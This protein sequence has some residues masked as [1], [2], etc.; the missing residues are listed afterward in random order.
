MLTAAAYSYLANFSISSSSFL[1]CVWDS[2]LRQLQAVFN[3]THQRIHPTSFSFLSLRVPETLFFF[4][5]SYFF[6]F[7][8][9]RCKGQQN[10]LSDFVILL[11]LNWWSPGVLPNE[12]WQNQVLLMPEC[13]LR[14]ITGF[15]SMNT[16][17]WWCLQ[18]GATITTAK[19]SNLLGDFIKQWRHFCF[20]FFS[21]DHLHS[22]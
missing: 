14:T 21:H 22:P 12:R 5:V 8:F 20:N 4:I 7:L 1:S 3:L 19:R 13:E 11:P 9:K 10:F 18:Y 6:F 15:L 2:V 17:C 16:S